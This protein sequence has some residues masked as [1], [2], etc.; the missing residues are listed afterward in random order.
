MAVLVSGTLVVATVML[1]IATKPWTVP[2]FLTTFD[3]N[4]N[5]CRQETCALNSS[6]VSALGNSSMVGTLG[7]SSTA[8]ALGNSSSMVEAHGNSS[9]VG[10]LGNSSMANASTTSAPGNVSM[11]GAGNSSM[12]S[13]NR[14]KEESDRLQ[15]TELFVTK[16]RY[17]TDDRL[18]EDAIKA[19]RSPPPA[20]AAP[21]I[22]FLFLVRGEI[23]YEPL[24][25]RYFAGHEDR[26]SLYVHARPNFTFPSSS[27]FSGRQIPSQDVQ[28]LSKTLADAIR[29]LF[30]MALLDWERNNMW[31]VNLCERT[32]PL[33]SFDHTYAYLMGSRHSFVQAFQ[34]LHR[35]VTAVQ[36]FNDAQLRKGEVWMAL[37]RRHTITVVVD[38]DVYQIFEAKCHSRCYFDEE[39]F[40]TL[41]HMKDPGGIANRTV[42]FVDWSGRHTSSPRSWDESTINESLLHDIVGMTEDSLYGQHHDTAAFPHNN[43]MHCAYNGVPGAACFLFA[44][45]FNPSA[46]EKATAWFSHIEELD[47]QS[48]D[49]G[50]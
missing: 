15:S 18:F 1:C 31:F 10:A 39:Y 19:S 3:L 33:R 8:S 7:N 6:T 35:Y 16:Y 27:F 23:P 12:A 38:R 5:P 44:R 28:R 41:L 25:R 43:T 40:Q 42:M 11:G 29:R 4:V 2:K 37:N 14:S 49:A 32:I 9:T 48:S 21:K 24:W 50:T 22:A 34:P 13:S 45:K 46:L 26:Y 17:S 36:H 47:A 30:A 20:G